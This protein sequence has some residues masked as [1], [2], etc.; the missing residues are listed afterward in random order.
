MTLRLRALAALVA[1]LVS[2]CGLP[3]DVVQLAEGLAS[4]IERETEA[5]EAKAGELENFIR[6]ENRE[7]LRPYQER[8]EWSRSFEEAQSEIGHARAL[9]TAE[10]APRL[11]ADRADDEAALREQLT[12]MR[13]SLDRAAELARAPAR[14]AAFLK[15]VK[16]RAPELVREASA[17]LAGASGASRALAAEVDRGAR[18]Y[19]EKAED[20]AGRLA[21]VR[22]TNDEAASRQRIAEAELGAMGRGSA[23]LAK[24]GD[25][26]TA[27]IAAAATV[28]AADGALRER[29]SELYRS[30]S[31]TLLDMKEEGVV[32][33]GRTSW[34]EAV[35]FPRESERRFSVQVSPEDLESLETWGDRPI[36]S[37]SSFFG[38]SN[39]KVAIDRSLWDTLRIDA[40]AGMAR[41]DNS[42]EFWVG[43]S[44]ALYYHRYAIVEGDESRETDW[45]QVS[46]ATYEEHYD[47]LGMDIVAKPYGMYEDEALREAAPPGMAYVGNPK[48]GKWENDAQGRRHWSWGQSFLF[49]YLVFGGPRH[50]YYHNDWTHYRGHRG[51]GGWYGRDSNAYGR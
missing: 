27:V 25:S 41:G 14:R 38:R 1:L 46:E 5:I 37:L 3:D 35:D 32:E 11:E 4:R 22:K 33:I 39:L 48:Y 20:L 43:E 36:A 45:E 15:D 13:G 40:L 28:A 51:G 26:T 47:D 8:E 23:D 16:D 31:R 42:A 7:W 50:Y 2:G 49:Y 34:N 18:D 30:Y 19:P 12:R 6:E 29:V 24:L 17:A 44:S 9:Y 21:A 10:V